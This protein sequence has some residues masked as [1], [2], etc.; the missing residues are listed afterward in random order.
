MKSRLLFTAGLMFCLSGI[1]PAQ[2]RDKDSEKYPFPL[3][4]REMRLVEDAQNSA[5]TISQLLEL[6]ENPSYKVRIA[7]ADALGDRGDVTVIPAL[8]KASLPLGELPFIIETAVTRIKVRANA[9]LDA[10]PAQIRAD[11]L[12]EFLKKTTPQS[13]TLTSCQALARLA[14]LGDPRCLT[15]IEE[16]LKVRPTGATSYEFDK[17]RALL[18][19]LYWDGRLKGSSLAQ[20]VDTLKEA[21]AD[22]NKYSVDVL[23]LEGALLDSGAP[24]I[25]PM[26]TLLSDN[27]LPRKTRTTSARVLMQLQHPEATAAL[28]RVMDDATETEEFRYLMMQMLAR[29]CAHPRA[30]SAILQTL[31]QGLTAEKTSVKL[32]SA[33]WRIETLATAG[34]DKPMLEDAILPYLNFADWSK[35]SSVA[36]SVAREVGSAKS[37]EPLINIVKN[38]KAPSQMQQQIM[39]SSAVT[40]LGYVGKYAPEKAIVFLANEAYKPNH[41]DRIAAVQALSRVGNK[42]VIPVLVTIIE[43]E[44]SDSALWFEVSGIY[45]A[46]GKDAVAALTHLRELAQKTANAWLLELTEEGLLR[47][48]REKRTN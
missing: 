32:I 10:N 7:A 20:K 12:F 48:E 34:A 6:L 1:S 47:L 35:G 43:K 28:L 16:Y 41:L 44:K 22:P 40:S 3:P 11:A 31:Q 45:R 36:A 38:G 19:R 2:E 29:Q 15:L 13:Q 14:K 21:T 9:P 39:R 27:A 25:A 42:A 46:G 8:Q 24:I 30:V 17:C 37:V 23:G 33:L 4:T 26:A 5:T 18:T